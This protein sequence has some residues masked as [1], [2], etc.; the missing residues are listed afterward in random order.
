M[1]YLLDT[2][3]ILWWISEPEQ[4]SSKARKIISDKNIKV[5]ISSVSI[6]E[7]S[8]KKSLGRLSFPSNL[9][10]VLESEGFEMLPMNGI[11]AI[12]IAELPL[13]HQDP[14]DR[15]LVMQAKIN[16]LVLITR[17][18]KIIKYPVVTIKA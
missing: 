4:I 3:V 9:I 2:H 10:Q 16:D 7:M 15:M 1:K 5:L 8:I 6:W 18:A 11:E 13:I 14:F 17:D 12:S